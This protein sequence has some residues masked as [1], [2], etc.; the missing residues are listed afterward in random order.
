MTQQ[1]AFYPSHYIGTNIGV[2]IV[3]SYMFPHIF[4]TPQIWAPPLSFML[5]QDNVKWHAVFPAATLAASSAPLDL[6]QCT[7]PST[8]VGISKPEHEP[9]RH[10]VSWTV[11]VAHLT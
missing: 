2:F 5:L 1:P 6:F 8:Q 4:T 10:K 11:N 9:L 3:Y 7:L